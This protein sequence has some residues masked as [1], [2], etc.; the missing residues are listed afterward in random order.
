M[1]NSIDDAI[2][3][4]QH[5]ASQHQAPATVEHQPSTPAPVTQGA[6]MSMA[7]GMRSAGMVVD[8]WVKADGTGNL[9][10][11]RKTGLFEEAEVIVDMTDIRVTKQI[12][13]G[14]PPTYL[15]TYDGRVS[16]RGRP[17]PDEIVAAQKAD[18]NSYDY[19]SFEIP[20][21]LAEDLYALNGKNKL[22]NAGETLGKSTSPTEAK[23]F[24]DFVQKLVKAGY[25]TNAEEPTGRYQVTVKCE[26]VNEPGRNYGKMVLT[27]P[28]PVEQ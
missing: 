7:D 23:P 18:P 16:T 17:W 13:F 22:A 28:R 12:R 21:T 10:L 4:A 14:D 1:T 11:A 2:E 8:Y 24:R 6:A 3:Q 9:S 27:N 5:A 25:E 15:K 20:M 26:A 19:F